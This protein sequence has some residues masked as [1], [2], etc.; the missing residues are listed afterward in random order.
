MGHFSCLSKLHQFLF[1][2]LYSTTG[3]HN[4]KRKRYQPECC[5][6]FNITHRRIQATCPSNIYIITFTWATSNLKN[7]K[8]MGR[9]KKEEKKE[10]KERG[11]GGKHL[12]CSLETNIKQRVRSAKPCLTR[13]ALGYALVFH[14]SPAP[15]G[16]FGNLV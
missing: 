14:W 2:C 4:F 10:G 8:K 11:K 6:I 3:F 13:T 12:K 5:E 7:R 15:S 9:N 16:Q 1:M